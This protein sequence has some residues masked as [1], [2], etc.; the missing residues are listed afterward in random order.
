MTAHQTGTR[1]QL[2]TESKK[3]RQRQHEINNQRAELTEQRRALPWVKVEKT[4]TL[5]TEEGPK[6]LDAL[7]DGRSQL[8]VYHM[9]FGP[10]WKAA[11][12]GCTHL[13]DHFDP[14]LPHLNARD[15]TLAVVSHAPL[16]KLSAYKRRMGWKV[17]VASSYTSNFNDDYGASFAEQQSEEIANQVMPQWGDNQ[18]IAKAAA[19]C[20]IDVREYVTTEAPGVD[21]FLREDGA[22]YH[23]YTSVPDGDDLDIGYYQFLNIAPKM[24]SGG[25]I[26]T[27][28]SDEYA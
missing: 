17:P 10:S 4:Y 5:D 19:S 8:I 18:D 11:C 27:Q 26:P 25:D 22:I 3:V 13:V 7:F 24:W 14:T 12:P 9:M 2:V 6:S 15:V 21:V 28:R 1:E 16:D 23:T 20:G